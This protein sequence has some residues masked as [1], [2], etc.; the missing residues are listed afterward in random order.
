MSII[1]ILATLALVTLVTKHGWN[2]AA[3]TEDLNAR[4]IY[5][6]VYFFLNS[7]LPMLLIAS[8]WLFAESFIYKPIVLSTF[9]D[10]QAVVANTELR[11]LEV[12]QIISGRIAASNNIDL[13]RS[14]EAYQQAK[15]FTN[16][17]LSTL[18]LVI[19]IIFWRISLK[20]FS[21]G[22]NA[23]EKVEKI[24]KWFLAGSSAIAVLTTLGIVLS[25][26]FETLQFF[27]KVP[28][29]DFLLG[30][31]WS[32]QTALRADQAGSS[33]SFGLLPLLSG[34][35]FIAFIAMA[36]A[37]PIGLYSAIYLA[38]YASSK[39]RK[40]MKPALEI[41]AGI[42]TVVYGFFAALTVAPFIVEVSANIGLE[43]S[44]ENALAAGIVMGAMIIPFISSLS[45]DVISS[46]PQALR[47]GSL[48]LG[49]TKAETIKKVVLPA[50]LPG[51]V[52]SVLL[53]FSRAVGETM[54]VVMA[55]GLAANLSANPLESVTTITAQIV[56]IL[57]GDQ[58]FDSPKT[59]AA[60][61]LGLTLFTVTLALNFIAL[62]VV[63][64]YKE[65]YE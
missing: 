9:T 7:L 35:L 18:I 27:Q 63:Q 52:S 48:A 3:Q 40:I 1:F 53:G 61:A 26:L 14:V 10:N 24:I 16:I 13:T 34:T 42:P 50:A 19:G 31:H 5:Y 15:T 58:S 33:G 30:T 21:K 23:R 37:V 25:L 59:L 8:L 22:F 54:I 47:D 32:P 29:F 2:K 44:S 39:T 28:F 36:I 4:P 51:I 49:A 20:Q 17:T 46:V 57:V 65:Q 55:A 64:K 62:R 12:K 38:E 41:L 11:Y 6:A 60:F 43:A 56:T 45:E